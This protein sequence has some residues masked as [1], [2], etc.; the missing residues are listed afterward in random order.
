M[1]EDREVRGQLAVGPR[2][3]AGVREGKRGRH[4]PQKDIHPSIHSQEIKYKINTFS[5]KCM[6]NNDMTV[7]FF[8]VFFFFVISPKK[9]E[10]LNRQKRQRREVQNNVRNK[11]INKGKKVQI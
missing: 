4:G 2:S 8:C 9:A 11:I 5:Q 7:C 3:T 6:E 1:D 10:E